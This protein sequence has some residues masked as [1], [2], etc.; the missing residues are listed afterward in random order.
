[1]VAK[2]I[3]KFSLAILALA[4]LNPGFCTAQKIEWQGNLE[5]A[6]RLASQSNKL[7]LVHF[8]ADWCRPCKQ[9]DTYVFTDPAVAR[10]L[11]EVA[12]PLRID[13]DLHPEVVKEFAVEGIPVDVFITPAGRMVK[14]QSTPKSS[15]NYLT[16][17]KDLRTLNVADSV[18]ARQTTQHLVKME[19]DFQA[20]QKN[21]D[22]F[23]IEPFEHQ[24]PGA[25]TSP[26][27]QLANSKD[28]Q[29]QTT[30]TNDFANSNSP[31]LNPP[32]PNTPTQTS[33]TLYAGTTTPHANTLNSDSRSL[34]N[35]FE[36]QAKAPTAKIIMNEFAQPKLETVAPSQFANN[37]PIT[38]IS[39]AEI[40]AAKAAGEI[41]NAPG[42]TNANDATL[43]SPSTQM[44]N[45]QK[46]P[47][48]LNG[49]C[50]VTLAKDGKWIS[51]DP[52]FG[53]VHRGKTYLFA[54]ADYQ[55]IFLNDPDQYSPLLAGYDPV[56]FFEQG[57]LMEGNREHGVF[58]TQNNQQVIVLF[59]NANT[60]SRFKTSPE[61]FLK[62]VRIATETIDKKLR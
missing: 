12:V 54:S 20:S 39:Q 16:M 37:G 8:H 58:M 49:D 57:E 43:T 2:A 10:A 44:P 52:K 6:K 61:K 34:A 50:P 53:C 15:E 28:I 46:S 25:I 48:A 21:Q 32:T 24:R 33:S 5:D 30:I 35:E 42:S 60:Q 62:A 26:S 29:S 17:L 45:E 4:I 59:R 31:T 27:Q 7:V 22:V 41:A 19:S 13:V 56:V 47:F 40:S 11:H 36:S 3:T 18:Q 1:M 14:K 23:S 55:Q 9:V 51:G 38:P